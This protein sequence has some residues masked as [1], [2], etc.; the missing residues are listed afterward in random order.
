MLYSPIIRSNLILL[1][2]DDITTVRG[3]GKV[4]SP[5]F[6]LSFSSY[7]IFAPQDPAWIGRISEN[8]YNCAVS[9]PNA[10][11]GSRFSPD[12]PKN[13]RGASFKIANATAMLQDDLAPY[14][15]LLSFNIKPL[16]APLAR[17]VITVKG[18]S[19]D[20]IDSLSWQVVFD[21]AYHLPLLVKMEEFSGVK[22]DRIRAVEITADYGE[23]ELDWEFT[24][25]DLEVQFFSLA[26]E[27]VSIQWSSWAKQAN[28]AILKGGARP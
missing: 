14:F 27:P 21:S 6:H 26:A 13:S 10:L 17:I 19:H 5:Y 16:D 7:D 18:Y 20:E 28:Q 11:I 4:P 9:P 3:L 25:D 8:D 15:S 2:F 24:V 23:D 22:W 1:K 12:D